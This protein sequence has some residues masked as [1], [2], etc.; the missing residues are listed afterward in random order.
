MKRSLHQLAVSVGL[1]AAVIIGMAPAASA[2]GNAPAAKAC[3]KGGFGDLVRADGTRFRNVGACASYAA[4]GGVPTRPAGITVKLQLFTYSGGVCV[5]DFRFT[6]APDTVYTILTRHVDT[7]TDAT[8]S[9]PARTDA[10]GRYQQTRLYG[11][12]SILISYTVN[13]VTTGL[14]PVTC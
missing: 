4:K 11:N 13:G 7:L 14:E 9:E 10:T 12:N 2:A 6:G 5:V 3:Q 8:Q 1:A